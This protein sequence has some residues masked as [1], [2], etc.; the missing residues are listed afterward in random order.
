[1]R[2]V[3][4][5]F[6]EERRPR[7]LGDERDRPFRNQIGHVSVNMDGRL[8]LKEIISA[9]A[10]RV[11]VVVDKAALETEEVVESMRAGS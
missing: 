6:E 8:I 10:A 9:V 7:V 3:V 5:H 11:L 4:G 1:M 2:R